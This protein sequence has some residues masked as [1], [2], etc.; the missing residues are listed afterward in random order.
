MSPGRGNRNRDAI[1]KTFE[2]IFPE[3]GNALEAAT[4]SGLRV[5][6]FAPHVP[7]VRFSTPATTK[8]S[9]RSSKTTVPKVVT[10]TFVIPF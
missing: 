5:N 9:S 10:T 4:G 8:M 2:E 6:Y 3:E 1:L 7:G